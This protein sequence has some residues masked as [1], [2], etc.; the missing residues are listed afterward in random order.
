[1]Q[2]MQMT[3][4]VHSVLLK[5]LNAVCVG[6]QTSFAIHAMDPDKARLSQEAINRR[7]ERLRALGY[8]KR[9]RGPGRFYIYTPTAKAG[10]LTSKKRKT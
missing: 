3:F 5:T 6:L 7:L 8:V 1:M 4:P 9:R 2:V 10:R